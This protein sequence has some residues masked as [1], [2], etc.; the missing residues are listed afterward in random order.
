MSRRLVVDASVTACASEKDHPVS[1]ACRAFLDEMYTVCHRVVVSPEIVRE[2]QDHFSNFFV[3]WLGAMQARSKIVRYEPEGSINLEQ[4]M[5]TEGFS[6]LEEAAVLKDLLLVEAALQTDKVVISRDER[7]R[8][9]FGRLAKHERALR[10]LVWVNPVLD[11]DAPLEW[12]RSGARLQR[13][14]RLG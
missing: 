8:K 13:D 5:T 9:L 2:W 1:S 12:L 10:T 3:V 11:D 4:A 14:R 6:S 7:A